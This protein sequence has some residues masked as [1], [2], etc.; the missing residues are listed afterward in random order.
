MLLRLRG[1]S[2]SGPLA[3]LPASC[4]HHAKLEKSPGVLQVHPPLMVTSHLGNAHVDTGHHG[5]NVGQ[6]H[7]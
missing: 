2:L 7:F 3:L 5:S 1:G 4:V 6:R